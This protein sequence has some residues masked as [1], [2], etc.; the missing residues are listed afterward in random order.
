[1]RRR[2]L[3][4]TGLA[5]GSCLAGCS[6]RLVVRSSG[7]PP[8]TARPAAS[9][10]QSPTA[11]AKQSPTP[12]E[13]GFPRTI[14]APPD[15]ATDPGGGLAWLRPGTS[16]P[17]D[18]IRSRVLLGDGMDAGLADRGTVFG[19]VYPVLSRDGG[20]SWAVD[21]PQFAHA[22]ADGPGATSR[23]LVSADGTLIAWGHGGN[24]VKVSS[25]A[26]RHWF[27]A[28]FPDGVSRVRTVR[29]VIV[30]RALGAQLPLGSET[31]PFATWYYRSTDDGR[32][33]RRST[34]GRP[35]RY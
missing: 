3:L 12:V 5:V 26:G 13:L 18:D 6:A 31:G 24:L 4:I 28:D 9:A 23:L 8:L 25:D 14:T 17:S 35:V 27:Q 30:V 19:S 1:V 16:V 33:Y 29:R 7:E 11:S 15:R 21:G 10:R 22:G 20:R 2:R 34:V 32:H